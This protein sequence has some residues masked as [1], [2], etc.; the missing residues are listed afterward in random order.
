M[1]VH[2]PNNW[3]WVDKNCF[4]WAKQYF[5]ENLINLKFTDNIKD[6]EI[7]VITKSIKELT[8]DVEVCQRK[9]KIIS[10]FDLKLSINFE[11]FINNGNNGNDIESFKGLINIPEIAYD[12]EIDEFQFDIQFLENKSNEDIRILIK[13][14]LIPE[15]RKK[16][17]KFGNDLI[18]IQGSD[19]QE[20]ES[21][22]NSVLTKQNQQKN[23]I[24]VKITEKTTF[25]KSSTSTSTSTNTTINP[26]TTGKVNKNELKLEST[27]IASAEQLYNVLL[28]PKLV[29]AW[30]RSST[31]IQPIDTSNDENKIF[32]LFNG[33]IIYKKL[34][35]IKKNE[36]I[37]LLWKLKNW[38]SF[39]NLKINLKQNTNDTK[40][41]IIFKNIPIG[42]EDIVKQNFEEYYFRSIKLTFGFGNN[43]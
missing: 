15:L 12:T 38:S 29:S 42:E 40:M 18:N 35:L 32:N 33:N 11:S 34:K 22:N 27:F 28:D 41:L 6:I 14:K 25:N 23:D 16:L 37:E 21:L 17:S 13:N 24:K 4:D 20:D 39:A 36:E 19:I 43:L 26:T 31:D 1:V 9:G 30:T 7:S 2:N 5:N 3:H 10:L 8:G